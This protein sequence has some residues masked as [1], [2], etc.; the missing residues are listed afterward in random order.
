MST[1][2]FPRGAF[3]PLASRSLLQIRAG[4]RDA[5]ADSAMSQPAPQYLL[6]MTASVLCRPSPL[7]AA[8]FLS[9]TGA[10]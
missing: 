1:R 9:A 4:S 7:S 6:A 5:C 2:H 10:L 8:F 3:R